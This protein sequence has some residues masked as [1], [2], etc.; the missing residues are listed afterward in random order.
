M[1]VVFMNKNLK[2]KPVNEDRWGGVSI[3]WGVE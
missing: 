3:Q 2:L 1:H